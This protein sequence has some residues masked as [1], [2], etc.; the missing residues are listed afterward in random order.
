[1]LDFAPESLLCRHF[2]DTQMSKKYIR[3]ARID[4][5]PFLNSPGTIAFSRE[6]GDNDH[7]GREFLEFSKSKI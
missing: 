7:F 6:R 5:L 2:F 1:M 4:P 3:W